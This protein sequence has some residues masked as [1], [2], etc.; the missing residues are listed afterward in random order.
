M[1]DLNGLNETQKIAVTHSNGPMMILAGAGSGKTRTLVSKISYLID[2]EKLS[3]HR[4]LALTFSN[5]AAKEMRERVSRFVEM[6]VGA[7]QITTFHAFCAKL[8]R[9]EATYLG[10]SR[11]FTIY[12]SSESKSIAK[13]ILS[14]HGISQ[15]E[16]SPFEILYYIEGLKNLGHSC[17][18]PLPEGYDEL[19]P[20]YGY[21]QEYERELINANAL[22]F[23]SLITSV[24][25]LFREFPQVLESYQNRFEYILVDEY[26]DT[27]KAQF[28]LLNMLAEKRK[29]ICVVGDEDQSI[30]SWR[31]ADIYNILDFE[32]T[33]PDTY[34]LKLEQNYRSSKNI[35]EAATYLI[36]RNKMRK[37]K[38]MWTDN[39]EG[40]AIEIQEVSDD[41]KEAEFIT[42]EIQKLS[43]EKQSLDDMAVFYRTNGQSR[44]IEDYLRRANI[45]YRIVGGIKFYERKEVKDV[46]AYLRLLTNEKDSL[47]F[48]RV[49]NT[50]ARGIGATT[51]RKLESLAVDKNLS[52][53]GVV[54][55]ISENPGDYKSLRLS[56]NVRARL[57]EFVT[58]IQ[59]CKSL[60]DAND[61]PSNIYEKIV[62]E[63][64][65]VGA[66][67]I[68]KDY[69]SIARLENLDELKNAI[70][71]FEMSSS[72]ATLSSF[73]ES[74]T[75][76]N[77][78]DLVSGD[79]EM[80]GEVSLMT[81]HGAKGLEFPYVFIAG[82]E[83][84]LFPS[85]KSMENGDNALEEERRLFYVAMTRAMKKLYII[86]AQG[87]MLF[88][89]LKFNGPSRFIMEIPERF[90]QWNKTDT[91]Y[92]QSS[93]WDDDFSQESFYD[94][95][96]SYQLGSDYYT[97][98]KGTFV[99]HA[100]YGDGKIQDVEG[101]GNE[102]KVT[103]KFSDGSQKKFLVK[104]APLVKIED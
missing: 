33:F 104:F 13:A 85:F 90:Y 46:I 58:L 39:P 32:K 8:L 38:K 34:I 40:D 57:L 70:V 81:V 23:G 54:E 72:A 44:I 1:V 19:D 76:D 35:I 20:L 83:E 60:I 91:E 31:G 30:Y 89:Q 87:R 51:L 36:E 9:S 11:S 82:V 80:N 10:L 96:P 55:L 5:K 93:D 68:K 52:L 61:K 4:I 64:G 97:F 62:H 37:G 79:K 101:T 67:K 26:Q 29:N 94:D 2:E 42:E 92:N 84:N 16:M 63:S 48:S 65:Y 6:D 43:N 73:L 21:Y 27:N 75:L 17:G 86:F 95:G 3:S 71:Q 24:I 14:R 47:A 78:N 28:I 25:K 66:L 77:T 98:P 18:D 100:I 88:G 99:S 49:I 15:K 102:E 69:E 53:W 45:S 103:I 22:D 59:D 56:K 12:D 50:P 7:L 41:K 74:I